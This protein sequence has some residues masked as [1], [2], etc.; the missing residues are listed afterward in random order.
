MIRFIDLNNGYLYDGVSPYVHWFPGQQSTDLIYT[1]KIC[2]LTNVSTIKLKLDSDV[3]NLIDPSKLNGTDLKFQNIITKQLTST[4]DEIVQGCS[5]HMIYV[6]AQS[7]NPGEYRTELNVN[8]GIK[9][10]TIQLG[11]D[12]HMENESLYINLSNMGVE[13]PDSIQKSL[14]D[15]NVRECNRDNITL[16]RKMKELLSN[17]WDVIANKGSYKSLLNSL[18][19][20][21][22]GDLIKIREIWKHDDFGRIVY[23]DRSLCSILE[24]KYLDT[25]KGF[26]KTTNLAL[27]VA[28]QEIIEG[29]Y[30]NEKNP[31]LYDIYDEYISKK[32][33]KW[34]E[35]DLMLKLSMLGNFYETYFMPIHLNLLHSTIENVVYTNTIKILNQGIYDRYD[36][37]CNINNFDCNIKNNST[38][39]LDNVSCQVGNNTMFGNIWNGEII[40]KDIEALGV[41]FVYDEIIKDDNE[42][43]TFYSQIYSGVGVIV[44]FECKLNIPNDECI[45]E[46]KLMLNNIVATETQIFKPTNNICEIK[47]N[48]LFKAEGTH[49]VNLQFKTN[50]SHIYTKSININIID[51]TGM[52]LKVYKIKH[53]KYLTDEYIETLHMNNMKNYIFTRYKSKNIHTLVQ[54]IPTT[55]SIKPS[56]V[57]LNNILILKGD[58]SNSFILKQHYHITLRNGELIKED[59]AN[60]YTV[61]ISK[62]FWFDPSINLT[63]FSKLF[64]PYVYRND[65]GFFP[66][67]HYLEEVNGDKESNYNISENDTVV[68]IP[69]LP[70]GLEIDDVDWEFINVTKNESIKL[71]NFQE[72]YIANTN[73]ELLSKGYYDVIFRFK[74]GNEMKQITRKSIF[75][76]V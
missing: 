28:K 69:E 11:A 19:W 59:P 15:V 51:V 43:K 45:V 31:Q 2:I 74:L 48:L 58:H 14:Y 5:M 62:S 17:Y 3:F 16:N 13:L 55:S 66:E 26:T 6:A 7:K 39:I 33:P 47:F 40:Y 41:D 25:L 30:D 64:K 32:I 42:L 50:G 10:Y 27:Y 71:P 36:H 46:S 4:S 52:D 63:N 73:G 21:E 34:A 8:T 20:F 70:L 56:G 76:K 22:W 9:N 12:F 18:K 72:P 37:M 35:D 57:C 65:Y 68:I 44:P 60:I 67:F 61:C 49:K 53:Y 24:D 23:D 75:N 29:Y 1:H 38:Y 54:Y